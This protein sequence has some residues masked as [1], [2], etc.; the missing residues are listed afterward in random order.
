MA[1]G[2]PRVSPVH[3]SLPGLPPMPAGFAGHFNLL[4]AAKG[5]SR[6]R[7]QG[8]VSAPNRAGRKLVERRSLSSRRYDP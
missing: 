1:G 4:D 3:G 5:V 8:L 2:D 7:G 6:Q